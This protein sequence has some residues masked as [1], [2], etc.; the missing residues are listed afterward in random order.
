MVKEKRSD[1]NLFQLVPEKHFETK[2][3][4]EVE[5]SKYSSPGL[6]KILQKFSTVFE[7]ELPSG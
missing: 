6:K 7:E 1:I 3:E 4:L 5:M 2:S